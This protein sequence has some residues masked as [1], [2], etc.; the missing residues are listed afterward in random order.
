MVLVDFVRLRIYLDVSMFFL[1]DTSSLKFRYV[2]FCFYIRLGT[3]IFFSNIDN[4]QENNSIR[5]VT[6][7]RI[8][9]LNGMKVD[10]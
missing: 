10:Y 5:E 7:I 1:I 9:E 2:L 8:V 6:I 3:F 4:N